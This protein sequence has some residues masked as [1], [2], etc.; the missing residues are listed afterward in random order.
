MKILALDLGTKTGFA[1]GD[2]LLGQQ[3]THGVKNFATK[4]H[5]G[6]G[7]RYLKFNHWVINL[8]RNEKPD[9]VLWEQ[10]AAHKGTAAAHIYGGFQ[11][12]LMTACEGLKVQYQGVPV[13]TIKKHATG[14]GNADKAKMIEA[15][16]AMGYSP[17]DDNAADAIHLYHYGADLFSGKLVA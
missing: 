16:K 6:A 12:Q 17:Q 11:A 2:P 9:I 7:V 1:F 5:E 13:G 10:V 4:Q 14:K 8:I 3:C 15:A